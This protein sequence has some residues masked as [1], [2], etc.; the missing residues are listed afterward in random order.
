MELRALGRTGIQVSPYALGCMNFG[1]P[2]VEED[3]ARILHKALDHGINLVDTADVYNGGASEEVLGRALEG[4]RDRVILATKGH[5]PTSDD[6]NDR[7]NSRRHLIRAIDASLRRLRTDR[8]DIYQIHR[9]DLAIDQT[10][11]LRALE[12]CVRAGKL[13]NIGCSTHPAWMIMEGHAIS[14]RYG[15]SKYVTEQPPYNLLDRRIELELI[16]FAQRH[17]VALITWSPLAMGTLAGRYAAGAATPPDGSR[18]ARLEGVYRDRLTDRA[19]A[20][21]AAIAVLFR[22]HDIDPIAGALT[23][24]RTRPGVTAAIIGPRTESHLDLALSTLGLTLPRSLLDA[25]DTLVPPGSAAANF[26][27][28][29]GWHGRSPPSPLLA[30][31]STAPDEIL[32]LFAVGLVRFR[33]ARGGRLGPRGRWAWAARRSAGRCSGSSSP[34]ASDTY[35]SIL[36]YIIFDYIRLYYSILD[37]FILCY[38]ILYYVRLYYIIYYIILYYKRLY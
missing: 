23:W 27:N 1:N 29:S 30:S 11:T 33:R 28:N 20:V 17:D 6:P 19:V 21:A 38:M 24:V 7:G 5:F 12:D 9:P 8:I 13:R 15:W 32:K 37:L 36:Y 25:L 14:D 26:L 35:Y 34:G 16:P 22:E 10:E 4:R 3:S 18:V 2:T 31:P